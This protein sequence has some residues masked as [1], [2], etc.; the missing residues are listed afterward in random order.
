MNTFIIVLILLISFNL[1]ASQAELRNLK[2]DKALSTKKSATKEAKKIKSPEAP[3]EPKEPKEPKATKTEKAPSN[4]GKAK[5]NGIWATINQFC[6]WNNEVVGFNAILKYWIATSMENIRKYCC[7]C[8]LIKSKRSAVVCTKSFVSTHL[9]T[10]NSL[11]IIS[12]TW[13]GKCNKRKHFMAPKM[14]HLFDLAQC[15]ADLNLKWARC[16]RL[17]RVETFEKRCV[18]TFHHPEIL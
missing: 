5:E 3:K 8:R 18:N 9:I 2:M 17:T 15:L 13:H 10:R 14:Q 7:Y 12:I 4:K 1:Q 6:V 11:N 16:K